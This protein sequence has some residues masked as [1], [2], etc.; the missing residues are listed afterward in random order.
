MSWLGI[1]SISIAALS[2]IFIACAIWKKKSDTIPSAAYWS[3]TILIGLIFTLSAIPEIINQISGVGVDAGGMRYSV[4]RS[5]LTQITDTQAALAALEVKIVGV[6][7]P[8]WVLRGEGDCSGNDAQP[9]SG[10]ASPESGRCNAAS[11]GKAAVC[12]DGVAYHN[13]PSPVGVPG[14]CTYKTLP[15]SQ[16][17]GGARPGKIYECVG[18]G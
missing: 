8:R 2:A 12:W 3:F 16:C 10:G 17:R 6:T 14:W 13:N 4:S 15:A 5:N 7:S 11:A 9:F 1:L 18:S